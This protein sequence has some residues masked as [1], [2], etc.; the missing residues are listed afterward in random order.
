MD[1]KKLGLSERK[2]AKD[3]N[4]A[5]KREKPNFVPPSPTKESVKRDG[6]TFTVK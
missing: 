5:H 1:A 4:A 3:D 6:T 2:S